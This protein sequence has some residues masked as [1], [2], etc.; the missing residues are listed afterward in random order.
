MGL[1]DK[2]N[3]MSD[4]QKLRHNQRELEMEQAANQELDRQDAEGILIQLTSV[5]KVVTLYDDRLDFRNRYGSKH[6]SIPYSQIRAVGLKKHTQGFKVVAA[7]V[8]SGVSLAVTNKKILMVDTGP[9]NFAFDFRREPIE[10][11][12]AALEIIKAGIAQANRPD[13]KVKVKR[14]EVSQSAASKADELRKLAELRNEGILTDDEFE[15][16]KARILGT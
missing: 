6:V 15:V 1:R 10:N 8:T 4:Q 11:V 14:A 12:E 7:V 5:D 16:E 13:V 2:I 3:E 9:D